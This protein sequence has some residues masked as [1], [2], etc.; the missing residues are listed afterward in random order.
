SIASTCKKNGF[1]IRDSNH[2]MEVSKP[3]CVCSSQIAITMIDVF[4]QFHMKPHFFK[5]WDCLLYL[6]HIRRTCRCNDANS[7]AFL[8]TFRKYHSS[9]SFLDGSF[10]KVSD[11][12]YS[13]H[14][15]I[16]FLIQNLT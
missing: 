2:L 4:T 10:L 5:E 15:Q 12:S 16:V 13:S 14:Q 9:S 6:F 8:S 3:L 7:I 11:C 1:Y